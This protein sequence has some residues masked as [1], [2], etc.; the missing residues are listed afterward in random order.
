MATTA[1]PAD[2]PAVAGDGTS[3]DLNELVS[4]W[5]QLSEGLRAAILSLVKATRPQI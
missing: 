3:R 5:P 1:S 2:S 4:A